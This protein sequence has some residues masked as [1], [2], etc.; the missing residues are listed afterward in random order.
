LKRYIDPSGAR[1]LVAGALN[2]AGTYVLFVVL[3]RYLPYR[4]AYSLTYGVGMVAG[5][6]AQSLWVFRKAPGVRTA[7]MFPVASGVQYLLG[8]ALLTALVEFGHLDPRVSAIVVIV[9]SVPLMYLMM[10]GVFLGSPRPAR[11]PGPLGIT[12]ARADKRSETK[13][14]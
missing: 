10:R 1:Y 11:V 4:W 9:V 13:W 14:S 12:R 6:L 2:T 5:Y 7:A 8:L 3:V